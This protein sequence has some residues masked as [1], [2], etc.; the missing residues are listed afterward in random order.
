MALFLLVLLIGGAAL[1]IWAIVLVADAIGALPTVLALLAS[2][3]L[4]TRVLQRGAPRAWRRVAEASRTGEKL[5]RQVLDAGI[6][7]VAGVLLLIPG[8]I[9]GALGLLLLLPPVRTV[10]RPALGFLVLRRVSLPVVVGT[11]GATWAATQTRSRRG[12]SGAEDIEGVVIV[13]DAEVEIDG[14]RVDADRDRSRDRDDDG[15]SPELEGPRPP[16]V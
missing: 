4:G 7:V 3:L 9:S 2:S 5:G 12:P 14:D 16:V 10:V 1:E 15:P 6:V 8:L 13:H 11:R